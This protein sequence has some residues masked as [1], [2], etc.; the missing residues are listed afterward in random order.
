MCFFNLI[1]KK[2]CNI[3]ESESRNL[4]LEILKQLKIAERL[5]VSDPFWSQFK[6]CD[7]SVKRQMGHYKIE[8][9]SNVYM[10]AVNLKEYFENF[11]NRTLNKK[12]KGRAYSICFMHVIVACM[13]LPFF[14][15][16]S[17]FVHF[18]PNF[19]MFWPF[20]PLF[21]PFSEKSHTCPLFL[22]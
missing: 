6:I 18:C 2:K 4:I 21:C 17:N 15:I 14:K 3:K 1:C 7:E 5:D 22:E 10:I 19:Q 9:I 20:L 11:K 8:N 16:F 13:R 12:H